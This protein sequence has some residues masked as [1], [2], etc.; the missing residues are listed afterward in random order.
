MSLFVKLMIG[1]WTTTLVIF[2][3]FALSESGQLFKIRRRVV[4]WLEPSLRTAKPNWEP[5]L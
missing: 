3:F 2:G 5:R 4:L 1:G